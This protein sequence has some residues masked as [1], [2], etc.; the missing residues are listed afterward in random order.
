[1][2][3]LF[4]IL[5]LTCAALLG[6]GPS[7]YVTSVA[8]VA[9]NPSG[10]FIYLAVNSTG[11]LLDNGTAGNSQNGPDGYIPPVA[12]VALNPS[13]AWTYLTVDALGSLKTAGGAISCVG[14]PGNTTGAWHQQCQTTGG[15]VFACN[16]ASGCTVAGDWVAQAGGGSGTVI[17]DATLT[18]NYF[19]LGAGTSHTTVGSPH[20]DGSNNLILPAGINTGGAASGYAAFTGKTSSSTVT[21][22][23][24]DSTG[25]WTLTLPTTGGTTGYMLFDSDGAGT[26]TWSNNGSALVP[27]VTLS[28]TTPA[29][30]AGSGYWLNNTASP[31]TANLPTVTSATV[32]AQY[33]VGNAAARASAVTIQLPASTYMYYKGVIGGAAGTLVSGGAAGD[34]VCVVAIDTTHYQALG[35]G[36]G[37]W[38]NN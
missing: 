18:A 8:P 31:W 33:C 2:K 12:L 24:N 34:I 6:Q 29:T 9:V 25:A 23:V 36:N 17:N 28:A 21:L 1:M 19:L 5:V 30:V 22:T 3:K 16:N 38:T 13:G 35:T 26:A 27:A 37:T 4:L 32:G 15:A 14:S 20:L 11:G 10:K 7:G